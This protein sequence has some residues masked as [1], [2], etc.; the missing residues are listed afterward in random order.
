MATKTVTR[1]PSA[2]AVKA[3]RTPQTE[4]DDLGLD[5]DETTE[6][7]A[8]V[9]KNLSGKSFERN[10]SGTKRMFT[11]LFKLTV[12][13]VIKYEGWDEVNEHP[14][15]HPN[16]FS[17]WEH[18]HPFRT[19]DKKGTKLTT[20]TPIGGH[21]H[22]VEWE[23]DPKGTGTPIIKSV[24]GPMVMGKQRIK[25]KLLN[26]PVPA[27]DYDDHTH[28]VEYIRSSEIVVSTTNIEAAKVIAW[29]ENKTAPI[30]GVQER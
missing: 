19:Y 8:P 12:A 18:T 26:V 22:V 9:T 4:I 29:E 14:E 7:Q 15:S 3:S 6:T 28:D 25:G 1:K 30:P 21:F 24:S 20:T 5:L 2:N 27:N 11:D 13:R 17:H 23:D 16:K 10:M